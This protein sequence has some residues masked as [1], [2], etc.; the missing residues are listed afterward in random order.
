MS[1]HQNTQPPRQTNLMEYTYAKAL[2]GVD[3]ATIEK[4]NS[5][6]MRGRV[7]CEEDVRYQMWIR[8]LISIGL[9][10]VESYGLNA[11]ALS[12]AYSPELPDFGL[13]G[14]VVSVMSPAAKSNSE[15]TNIV[16]AQPQT[17]QQP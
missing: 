7:V 3:N 11:N 15:N 1:H 6:L 12:Y 17:E 10:D 2:I 5:I 9:V 13:R 14:E 4:G 16:L 8:H